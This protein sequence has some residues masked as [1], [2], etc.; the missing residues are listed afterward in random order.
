VGGLGRS[1]WVGGVVWPPGAA[2]SK[3]WENEYCN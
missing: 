1:G 3:G 2:K